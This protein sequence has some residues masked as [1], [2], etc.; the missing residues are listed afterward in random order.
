MR[1]FGIILAAAVLS[2]CVV[3]MVKSQKPR[4]GP[5]AEVGYIDSGGGDVRYSTQGWSWIVASRR[6]MALRRIKLFCSP[7]P[8][9]I[10]DD[11]TRQDVDATYTSDDVETTL[12][13]GGQHYKVSKY[14]HI[15]F[16]CVP[17]R[18]AQK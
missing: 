1:L 10:D 17:P 16:E 2:G 11:V 8:F 6:T 14:H 3:E 13:R 4:K 12:E 7:L 5:V 18:T 9:K 15:V